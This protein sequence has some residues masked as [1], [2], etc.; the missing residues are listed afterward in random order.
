MK[1][2]HFRDVLA[3]AERGSVRAAA[4]HL[5]V[6]Q[7]TLTRSIHELERE[8]GAVL[9]ERGVRGATLTATGK[10]F[11]TR[12]HTVM[13]EIRRARDEI[14]QSQGSARG[15]VT[16]GL[17]SVP[18]L[19]LLPYALPFFRERY[20]DVHLDI[21]DG[22]FPALEAELRDGTIDCYIGPPPAR[23]TAEG[24]NLEKLFD[25]TRVILARKGHPL[26][27]AKSLRELVDAKWVTTSITYRSDEELGPLF[28]QCG[29]PAPRVV[30]Q[31]HSALT[32]F[33]AVAFSDLLMMLP[34]QWTEFP[35]TRDVL[36]KIDVVEQLPAPPIFI[37]RRSDIP[38]TPATSFFCDLMRRAGVHM[39][40]ARLKANE[41][42]SPTPRP[43]S[44]KGA[45]LSDPESLPSAP[46]MRGRRS[47][48]ARARNQ[49]GKQRLPSQR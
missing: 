49:S 14:S 47:K 25:N 13:T 35:L 17:S 12:A 10:R 44:R 37:V 34:I 46:G 43:A 22:L 39:A 7:P 16:V 4:R 38:M 41:Q 23:L 45:P 1:L 31:A 6:A 29:L 30:M 19:A 8:L 33:V 3:V 48:G 40:T 2:T 18:H 9:F 26:A 5:R 15:T 11:V 27:G 32:F 24:L 20:P 36:Q 42:M 21:R 28:A